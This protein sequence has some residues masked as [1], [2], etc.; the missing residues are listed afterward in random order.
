MSVVG[1][2]A[3]RYHPHVLKKDIP[4]L[5]ALDKVS[6]KKAIEKKLATAPQVFGMPLRHTLKAYWKLRVGDF[7]VIYQILDETVLIVKIGHRRE[8]Y[9][10]WQP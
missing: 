3:V 9:E 1:D 8:V 6:I 7:R 2:Y 4:A 10:G 5:S